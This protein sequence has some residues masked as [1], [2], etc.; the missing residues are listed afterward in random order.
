MFDSIGAIDTGKKGSPVN[1][2]ES[3]FSIFMVALDGSQSEL[4]VTHSMQLSQIKRLY[5]ANGGTTLEPDLFALTHE[6][7]QLDDEE[8]LGD[9]FVTA[10]TK[11][12]VV[13]L[14]EAERQRILVRRMNGEERRVRSDSILA[15]SMKK[16]AISEE[17]RKARVAEEVEALIEL[18]SQRV[19]TPGRVE[20]RARTRP[21]CCSS[22]F[23]LPGSR[24]SPPAR[25]FLAAPP[26][27]IVPRALS[28]AR[29]H[30]VRP[31]PSPPFRSRAQLPVHAR[32][33]V[34]AALGPR[35][36]ARA[37]LHRVRH[38]VRGRTA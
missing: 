22:S 19:E 4:R 20:T 10:S 18:Y 6:S 33:Q 35:D 3:E 26:P 15:E 36:D 32:L 27:R 5:V 31:P 2:D 37:A 9:A 34:R 12:H 8:T 17:E 21:L 29:S 25:C 28:R 16:Y 1:T 7:Y 30:N 13:M 38:A 23:S 24:R 14:T 11:L